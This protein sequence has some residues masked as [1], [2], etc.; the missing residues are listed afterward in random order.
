VQA[1]YNSQWGSWLAGVEADVQGNSERAKVEF[2]C[3]GAI[4]NPA[5]PVV[6][7]FDQS[8]KM[9][10][11]ATLRARL[12]ATVT[13]DILV[14]VT[15]GLAGAGFMPAG[16]VASF[17]STVPVAIVTP[18]DTLKLKIG[19]AAGVGVE[20]HLGGPWTGKVEYLHLDF[21]TFAST[22]INDLA[23]PMAIVDFNYRI[24]DN[25][26]RVGLNYKF[27][28]TDVLFAKY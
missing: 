1:G 7:S 2:A 17:D 28:G 23:V 9:E 4:C 6:A 3:P 19:W 24:T 21:G 20:G 27:D 15:G 13:P 12:G 25:I 10:W 14:Y 16:T 22:A 26:V 18:F 11:F 5:G 8:L